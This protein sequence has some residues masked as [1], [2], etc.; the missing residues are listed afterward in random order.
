[1]PAPSVIIDLD[2]IAANT[3]RLVDQMSPSEVGIFG[4][5]KAT[6]GSPLVARA[7][8]RGG[9]KAWRIRASTTSNACETAAS[10]RRS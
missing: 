3:R 8:L 7:M 2:V 5:V 9:A 4:V 6:C 1:M 10:P